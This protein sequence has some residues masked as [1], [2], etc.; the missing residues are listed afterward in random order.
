MYT[1]RSRFDFYVAIAY[2]IIRMGGLWIMGLMFK[3][4]IKGNNLILIGI[5]LIGVIFVLIKDRNP[6]TIGFTGDNLKSNL[7]I[8]LSLV[9]VSFV[10][11]IIAGRYKIDMLVYCLFYYLFLIA[12]LEE[13]CYRGI[14]QNYLFGLRCNKY[15]IY[16]IGAAM[17]SLSHLPFQMYVNN[18]VSF[19]YIWKSIPQL[20]LLF[21]MHLILC[22]I[23]YRRKSIIIPIALHFVLDYLQEV[24]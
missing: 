11:S 12:L 15:M 5:A 24:I 21:F 19:G 16:L 14:I 9:A 7:I 20:I 18:D 6:A 23:A 2:W 8:S 1:Q 17:F 4:Q 10:I 3:H 22:F 13:I